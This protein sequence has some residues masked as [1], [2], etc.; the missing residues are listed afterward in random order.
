MQAVI[1]IPD[2]LYNTIKENKYDVYK[3][4]IYD[5]I[6]QGTPLPKH[7][8]NLRILDENLMTQN[9]KTIDCSDSRWLNDVGIA[10]STIKTIPATKE[11]KQI[12]KC[13]DTCK[14]DY[15]NFKEYADEVEKFAHCRNCKQASCYEPK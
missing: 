11:E 5:V 15:R 4:R 13:C 3:G 8:G 14:W 2:D 6:R 10:L 9:L 7:E 1:E 12:K